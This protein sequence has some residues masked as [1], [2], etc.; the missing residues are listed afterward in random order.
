MGNGRILRR[1]LAIILMTTLVFSQT[2]KM[3]S[4][5]PVSSPWHETIL[6]LGED[7]AEISDGKIKLK[8]YAGGILG[9]E[10]DM[11]RKMRIGQLHAAALT[12]EGLMYIIPEM[13][14]LRMPM[15]IQ[16]DAELNH[17]RDK[18]SDHFRD[19]LEERGFILLSWSDAGWAHLF[20]NAPVIYPED[21]NKTNQIVFIWAGGSG[22]KGWMDA[23]YNAVEVAAPDIFM[24][25]QTGLITSVTT[26]PIIALSYQWFPAV[27]FTTDMK[28]GPLP[29]AIIITKKGWNKISKNFQAPI[30]NKT[31]ERGK[32]LSEEVRQLESEALKIMQENGLTYIHAPD[33][34]RAAWKKMVET[35]M[36]PEIFEQE[37]P[38]ELYLQVK[39]MLDEYH[40][41]SKE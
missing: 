30:L 20:T 33:D 16:T 25:L 21:L 3:G 1:G 5:A 29:G 26:T 35:H 41:N 18:L 19:L 28:A 31:A 40:R 12:I 24:S 14:V 2:I 34:A 10:A 38:K 9:D 17:V 39:D 27:P 6:M 22:K 13:D 11:V 4:L 15:L 36:Y 7:W 8:L 23:G 32:T 37:V